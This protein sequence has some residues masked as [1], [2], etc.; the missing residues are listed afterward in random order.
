MAVPLGAAA[1][2][3]TAQLTAKASPGLTVG[4]RD[5]VNLQRLLRDIK[6][7]SALHVTSI[8]CVWPWSSRSNTMA[9]KERLVLVVRGRA[10]VPTSTT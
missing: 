1:V 8:S 4:R 7:C 3:Q 5:T 10:L 2:L 6:P 9:G